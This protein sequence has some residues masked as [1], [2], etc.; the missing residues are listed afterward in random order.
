[1][2]SASCLCASLWPMWRIATLNSVRRFSAPQSK[3]PATEAEDDL[4]HHRD[5]HR[6]AVL[7]AWAE[8][9]LGDGAASLLVKPPAHA[10]E[11]G[12]VLGATVLVD[13]EFHQHD[14]LYAREAALLRVRRLDPVEHFWRL[15]AGTGAIRG[16]GGLRACGH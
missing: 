15:D 5:L 9:P 3:Y 1:M 14:P 8:F 13:D 11:N 12:D 7:H 16:G 6:L 10:A 2:L 4:F